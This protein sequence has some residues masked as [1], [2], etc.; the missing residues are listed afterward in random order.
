MKKIL[1]VIFVFSF[2]WTQCDA[3]G[4]GELDIL[5]IIE[6][7][8][9][10][11]DG[12]WESEDECVSDD[13]CDIGEICMDGVCVTDDGG[14]YSEED[15]YGTWEFGDAYMEILLTTNQDVTV[16]DELS[17]GSGAINVTGGGYELALTYLDID[18]WNNDDYYEFEI[19]VENDNEMYEY[20]IYSDSSPDSEYLYSKF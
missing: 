13:D 8:N 6:E 16:L 9:C 19:D 20:E 5:D 2:V 12:C 15:F 17:P 14:G 3:N 18:E 4:D 10:I 1:L 11:L 7:V